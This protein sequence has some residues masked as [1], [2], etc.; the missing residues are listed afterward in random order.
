MNFTSLQGHV[1]A[2]YQRLVE[3]FGE[4]TYLDPS[5]DGKVNTEW[6][7][8]GYNLFGDPMPV[9]IYDWKEY[10]GGQRS[11][12]G[13]KYEWHIGGTDRT[14]VNYVLEMLNRNA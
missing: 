1:P 6:E 5:D 9:T 14:A 13:L 8:T 7:L 4:P 2:T 11:R 3:V 12:S 10:D